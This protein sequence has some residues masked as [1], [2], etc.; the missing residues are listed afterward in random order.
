MTIYI[1]IYIYNYITIYIY[2]YLRSCMAI[3]HTRRFPAIE[4][5]LTEDSSGRRLGPGTNILPC[6]TPQILPSARRR[7][8]DSNRHR[9]TYAEKKKNN[10]I[11]TVGMY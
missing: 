4:T 1:Y 10:K 2:I 5:V 7:S 11:K 8:L 6:H 9:R 3:D